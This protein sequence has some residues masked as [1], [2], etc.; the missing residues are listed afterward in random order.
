MRTYVRV[1]INATPDNIFSKFGTQS[2]NGFSNYV[3]LNVINNYQDGYN[4]PNCYIC[5]QM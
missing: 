5:S 2:L 4:I 3:K 1:C